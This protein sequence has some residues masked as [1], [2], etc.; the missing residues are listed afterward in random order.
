MATQE[1]R[2]AATRTKLI[3]TSRQHFALHGYESTHTSDILND[4]GLS[5]GALYH[6][7]KSKQ[8]LFEAVFITIADETIQ[9]ATKHPQAGE[10]SL[11]TLISA[12]IT[13]LRAVQR[14]EVAA[15][16]LDQGPR[17]LGW[18]RA[19]DLEAKSSLSL[20]KKSLERAIAEGEVQVHSVDL[21]ARFI[22]AMLTEAALVVLL[23]DPGTSA[24]KNEATIR[25]FIE[26]LRPKC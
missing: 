1:Q 6:H 26:G 20:M 24:T 14:P 7:F 4:T 11:E 16:L 15:I 23:K 5:R 21:T 9:Y 12:C 3:D 25:Q 19:R 22:N 13:W 18:K 17:V 2:R 10:S 8:D